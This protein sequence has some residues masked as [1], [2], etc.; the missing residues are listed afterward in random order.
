MEVTGDVSDVDVRLQVGD[1]YWK[2]LSGNASFDLDH[3]GAWAASMV[4]V[5]DDEAMLLT[6]AEDL[7]SE[8]LDGQE[9]Y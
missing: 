9:S 8:I 7:I 4:D 6:V 2:I 3:R 1:G 5:E